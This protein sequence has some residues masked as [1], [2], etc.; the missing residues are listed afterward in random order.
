[1][2]RGFTLIELLIVISIIAVLLALSIF[3]LQGAR[4]SA[5]DGRRKS[6][7]EL[8]RSGIEA[9]KSDCNVYP[10]SL[11]AVGSALVGNGSTTT[12][13]VTNTYISQ[14]PGDPLNPARTYLYSSPT[15]ATYEICSALEN[16]TGAATCGSSTSCG[17]GVTC[18]YKVVNP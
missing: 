15:G 9:Y 16:G 12:C 1:M 14:M 7:L 5:R 6:D 3:G 17:S 13:L 11:P 18:N 2:R 4:E 8:V 10:S